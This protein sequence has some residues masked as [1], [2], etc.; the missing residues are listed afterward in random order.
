MKRRLGL[1][2]RDRAQAA[3][4]MSFSFIPGVKEEEDPGCSQSILCR[5]WVPRYRCL[6]QPA[7]HVFGDGD[8]T[9]SCAVA[10]AGPREQRGEGGLSLWPLGTEARPGRT[11]PKGLPRGHWHAPPPHRAG[12]R[13]GHGPS[14]ADG[15]NP[16]AQKGDA[17]AREGKMSWA[18]PTGERPGPARGA[19]SAARRVAHHVPLGCQAGRTLLP[20]S[21]LWVRVGARHKELLHLP[22]DAGLRQRDAQEGGDQCPAACWQWDAVP[23]VS[24]P[25]AHLGSR[26]W[27]AGAA[28]R[29][30]SAPAPHSSVRRLNIL[31]ANLPS[32]IGSQGPARCLPA[33]HDVGALCCAGLAGDILPAG[34]PRDGGIARR[35]PVTPSAACLSR[36]AE[37]AFGQEKRFARAGQPIPAPGLP[38]LG[39]WDV[40]PGGPRGQRV[41]KRLQSS[42][43]PLAPGLGWCLELAGIFHAPRLFSALLRNVKDYV[44]GKTACLMNQECRIF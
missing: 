26:C 7:P 3:P 23:G 13:A 8:V 42:S 5:P 25:P 32:A 22:P 12:D 39:L 6:P 16:G 31:F 44:T 1:G 36:R 43:L 2:A 27:G 19:E 15:G 33:S 30:S 18:H 28:V 20:G 21:R 38:H 35:S 14:Q 4:G 10:F 9:Q 29:G 17:A 41:V 24:R 40:G 11:E 37:A 34:R